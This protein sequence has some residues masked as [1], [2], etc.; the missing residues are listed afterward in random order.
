V[1]TRLFAAMFKSR[2]PGNDKFDVQSRTLDDR[3]G[4]DHPRTDFDGD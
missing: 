3:L 2:E 4:Y 1:T